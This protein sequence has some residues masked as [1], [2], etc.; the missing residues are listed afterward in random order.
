M[1]DKYN[2]E[3]LLLNQKKIALVTII[4][5]IGLIKE[6][7]SVYYKFPVLHENKL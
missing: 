5:V 1:A 6:L 3:W 4:K 7:F 2:L